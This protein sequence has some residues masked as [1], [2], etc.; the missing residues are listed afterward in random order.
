M[1]IRVNGKELVKR[2]REPST[3]AGMGMIAAVF[4]YQFD[5]RMITEVGLAVGGLLSMF[6][7]EPGSTERFAQARTRQE[8][9][10]EAN[11]H[12]AR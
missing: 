6:L 8:D 11:Q 4:G 3:Y 1:A 2:L 5:I 12:Q 10:E 7:P 9:L